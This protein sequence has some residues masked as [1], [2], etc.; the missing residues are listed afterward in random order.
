MELQPIPRAARCAL[1]NVRVGALR[2]IPGLLL[3]FLGCE[4]TT[5]DVHEFSGQPVIS[6]RSSYVVDRNALDDPAASP[7]D[8]FGRI[9]TAAIDRNEHLYIAD[10]DHGEIRVFANDESGAIRNA[11]TIGGL[12]QNPGEYTLLGYIGLD[13]SGSTL[14]AHDM[15]LSRV[16]VYATEGMNLVRHFPVPLSGL[17][18]M[19][20]HSSGMLVFAGY[21]PGV[22]ELVHVVDPSG[23][24]VR[25]MADLLE[26]DDS[27]SD[28]PAVRAA[29]SRAV[30][31]ELPGGDLLVALAAP[32]RIARITLA[33]DLK[34]VMDDPVLPNPWE[35][36]VTAGPGSLSVSA[37]PEISGVFVLSDD[38]FCVTAHDYEEERAF[39]DLRSTRD[40]S[41]LNR[42]RMPITEQLLTTSRDGLAVLR[43]ATPYP[44]FR[45]SHLSLG[46]ADS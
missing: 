25:S 10:A 22:R 43:D 12:G 46:V 33:G 39:Y 8:V 2:L 9:Q 30:V 34:W 24:S 27:L 35:G 5:S 38:V 6:H 28:L 23:Q 36:Y 7:D 17:Q 26:I 20:V 16:D 3:L 31:A 42:V 45:V 19:L 4:E 37:Y 41:L 15:A 11:N 14:Y 44:T 21:K 1:T 13:A 18:R 40:G 29:I 32:Y